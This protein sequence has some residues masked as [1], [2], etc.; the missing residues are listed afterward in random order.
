MKKLIVQ[1][2][3]GTSVAD[4]ERLQCVMQT[5]L[6]TRAQ[7]TEVVVVLS[8]MS[9]ETD[10]LVELAYSAAEKP[11]LRDYDS[12]I[13]TGEQ[14]STTLLSILLNAAGHKAKSLTARQAGLMTD[15]VHKKAS[16][17]DIN[18]D[19]LRQELANGIIPVITGFQGL[20]SIGDITTLGRGGSDTTAVALAA[21]LKADECQI[22]TDVDGVYT[23]DPR[24]VPRAQRLDNITLEEMLEMASLGAKVLQN[25]AVKFA[26]KYKVPLRVLSSFTPGAGT[27][28][29]YEEINMEKA[30]VSGIAFNRSEAK[31]S[32]LGIPTGAGMMA[33]IIGPMADAGIDIDMILQNAGVDETFNVTFT[34]HRDEYQHSL[35]ML[36]DICKQL[37]AKEVTG[38]MQ[39]AKVSVI[40]VG[41]RSHAGVASKVFSTLG[42]E[43]IPVQLVTTSEIKISVVIAEKYLE[44][45]AR[46][47][48]TVFGLDS[49]MTEEFDPTP[50]APSN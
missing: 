14:V 46:S 23:A 9:G 41:M 38:D 42:H 24:I 25:R 34:V 5:V 7:D 44:L 10:R 47:L 30:V 26:G 43:G 11:N 21:A 12:L 4:I 18:V 48:H 45:A 15:D 32:L 28:I 3:G 49:E 1:K 6:E 8:A 17:I 35:S 2:F 29:S 16:I 20:N 50:T 13:S 27:L 31:L 22:F 37:K 33:K 40:G 36:Q 39:I 19:Y